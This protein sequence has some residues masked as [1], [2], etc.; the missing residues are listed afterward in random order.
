MGSGNYNKV[1]TDKGCCV[2]KRLWL[3]DPGFIFPVPALIPQSPLP[4]FFAPLAAMGVL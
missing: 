1:L 4:A 2:R 3:E